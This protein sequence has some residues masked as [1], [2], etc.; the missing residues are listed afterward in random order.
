MKKVLLNIFILVFATLPFVVSC[1]Q[2]FEADQMGWLQIMTPE[3]EEAEAVRS[4]GDDIDYWVSITKGEDV[5]KSPQRYSQMTGTISLSA[6]ASYALIAESCT[7]TEAE[8]FPSIYGQPRYVGIEPFA[9]VAGESTKVKVRCAMGNA[10]F[11]VEKD[12][13]FYYT[14]Y[15]VTATLNH[16]QL[17]F[18]NEQKIGYFNVGDDGTAELQY[19]VEAKDAQ[20]HTGRG[21]GVITLKSR[22]LSKLYL[23][24]A[25]VGYV[26]V[27]VEYDD[28]FTPI[29][30]DIVVSE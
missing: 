5:V 10:A 30:T 25:S 9:I 17:V 1:M 22:N 8:S 6:G 18:D 13:S 19:V 4:S 3:R 26:D 21:S 23:K 24:A 2:D 27:V 20:G 29:V 12:A 14:E 7:K 11:K 16:R 28:T 15:K